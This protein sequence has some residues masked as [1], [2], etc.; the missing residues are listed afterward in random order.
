MPVFL[1][2]DPASSTGYAR[3][4]LDA[5]NNVSVDDYG[6]LE[7][8]NE[9]GEIFCRVGETCNALYAKVA[10]LIEASETP[11]EIVYIEDFFVSA[12]ATRGVNLNLYLRGAISMLLSERNIKYKFLSPSEWKTFVTGQRGGRPTK[13]EKAAL[14]RA[15]NKTI[16]TDKLKERYGLTFPEKIM[17]GGKMRK[18]KYDISD[19]IG[20]CFCGI[21][22]DFPAA[23]FPRPETTMPTAASPPE[24][25]TPDIN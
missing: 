3:C 20:I 2:L 16:I 24:K 9:V 12:R 22:T 19:A 10:E 1:A 7:V 5:D 4:T 17:I 6:I 18:F 21:H 23:Q 14:G 25:R 15:A 13:A 8:K 11:P